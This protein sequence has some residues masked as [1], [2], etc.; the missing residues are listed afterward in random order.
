MN[1]FLTGGTGFV[2]KRLIRDLAKKGHNLYVLARSEKK[3]E[4]L[5]NFLEE[6]YH[7]QIN[8]VYGDVTYPMLGVKENDLQELVGNIDKVYHIA[9][10]VK[11]DHDLEETLQ[12]INYDGTVNTLSFAD[13]VNVNSFVYVSTAYTLGKQEAGEETLYSLDND[14]N[15][16][17]EKTKCKAEH[18]VFDYKDKFNVSIFR[19][20]I[21]VGDS[22]TGEA[23]S[24]FT[25]YGLM[26]GLELFKKRVERKDT[27]KDR[28]FHILGYGEGTSNFVPVDY[29]VD[30]LSLAC[31]HAE[32][33]KIYH[34][35]NP[36]APSNE[37]VLTLIK[38]HLKFDRFGTTNELS[39][40]TKE[41]LM[42]N[43]MIG[44]FR[45]YLNRNIQFTCKNTQVLL[46]KVN[47]QVLNMDDKMLEIIISGYDKTK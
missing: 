13:K 19:P 33:G 21:I 1:V 6:K 15:N 43:S 28:V 18:A 4:V 38:E 42:M 24:V 31:E 45:D 44:P 14:F 40:L 10:L 8:I 29:V 3:V 9:A 47:R 23:D 12:A 37:K 20:S 7:Q 41:E 30:V 17:Y 5:Y 25:L 39:S 32:Q 11:F 35:T 27:L 26:R 46:N 16:P 34:I 36:D 2:G 22:K